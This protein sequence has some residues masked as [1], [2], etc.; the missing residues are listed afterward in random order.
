MK[1]FNEKLN[2]FIEKVNEKLDETKCVAICSD[3]G[4]SFVKLVLTYKAEGVVRR[5]AFA[6]IAKWKADD[7]KLKRYESGDIFA[8]AGWDKIAL[9]KR[10]SIFDP[11]CM[12]CVTEIGIG[13]Y[14]G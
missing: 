8:A 12:D 10:G 13:P 3:Y 14:K 4:S 7:H 6:F 11:N 5:T 1:N 2:E 9:H